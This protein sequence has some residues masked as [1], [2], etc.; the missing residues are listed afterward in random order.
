MRIGLKGKQGLCI[1]DAANL[2]HMIGH[3]FRKAIVI[4]DSYDGNKVI[5]ATHRVDLRYPFHLYQCVGNVV[6]LS[7][8]TFKRTIALTTTEPPL[9]LGSIHL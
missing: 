4:F 3:R 8:S 5:S 6:Y 7:R 2:P 9:T 1:Q